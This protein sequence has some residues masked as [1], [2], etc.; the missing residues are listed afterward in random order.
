MKN[1]NELLCIFMVLLGFPFFAAAHFYHRCDR[2][3]CPICRITEKSHQLLLFFYRLF[4]K[5][6]SALAAASSS[7]RPCSLSFF[8]QPFTLIALRVKLSD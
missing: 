5:K 6:E 3:T 2:R 4:T 8:T 7:H 1:K